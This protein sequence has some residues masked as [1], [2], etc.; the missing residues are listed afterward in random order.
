[1]FKSILYILLFISTTTNAQSIKVYSDKIFTIKESN[2][3]FEYKYNGV[4][5]GKN[6]YESVSAKRI[7]RPIGKTDR[8]N[9]PFI[10]IKAI[11]RNNPNEFVFS[12]VRIK[13]DSV[14]FSPKFRMYNKLT[15]AEFWNNILKVEGFDQKG[16]KVKYVVNGNQ[17]YKDSERVISPPS[18]L[19]SDDQMIENK[20]MAASKLAKKFSSTV[21]CNV[22]EDS[23]KAVKVVTKGENIEDNLGDKYIIYWEGDLGCSGGNG[24]VNPHF[25][26]VE[27]SSFKRLVVVPDI[28]QP[29]LDLVCVDKVKV[30]DELINIL[31]VTYGE[32]DHQHSPSE[33]IQYVLKFNDTKNSFEIMKKNVRPNIE[34]SEECVQ[35]VR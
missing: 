26:I 19:E 3:I 35:R 16:V 2:G 24:S 7:G 23:F 33:K 12:L 1:M 27:V 21:A 11:P 15:N 28:K 8:L 34:I 13:N 29:E 32:S 22:N 31:G 14:T 25:S 18:F 5:L 4:L 9:P 17:L 10:L 20:Q 6:D 30:Q